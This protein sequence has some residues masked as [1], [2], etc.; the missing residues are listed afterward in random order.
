[1][2]GGNVGMQTQRWVDESETIILEY[3][4]TIYV[5]L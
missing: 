1:M 5:A 3:Q 4:Y 2:G